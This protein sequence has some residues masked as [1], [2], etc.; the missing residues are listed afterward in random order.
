MFVFEG[1]DFKGNLNFGELFCIYILLVEIFQFNRCILMENCVQISLNSFCVLIKI[2]DL[3]GIFE[4][5]DNKF[6]YF[7]SKI[8]FL[9]IELLNQFLEICYLIFFREKKLV[10]VIL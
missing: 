4:F 9:L 8:Y 7:G 10:N 1:I 6:L 5:K 3:L 2:F